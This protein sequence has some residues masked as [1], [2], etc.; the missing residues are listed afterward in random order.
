MSPLPIVLASKSQARRAV[1][2]GAGVS[3]SV[4]NSEVDEDAIKTTV[5]KAGGTP[6]SVAEILAE[7]KAV[8]ISQ[9]QEGLVIG[10][11]QTLEFSGQLYDKAPTLAEARERL[12][13]LRGAS[14]S[15]HSAVAVAEGGAVIWRETVSATLTM[16]SF[17]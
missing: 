6:K 7:T 13:T 9:S 2:S 14:H 15:L 8:K 4:A 12:K 16:R 5:M 1:L 10:A 11:D 17:S 3:F